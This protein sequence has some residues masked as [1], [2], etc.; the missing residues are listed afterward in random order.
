MTASVKGNLSKLGISDK[1]T[2]APLGELKTPKNTNPDS[3]TPVWYLARLANELMTRQPILIKR[4]RYAEGHHDLPT[5]DKRYMR[6]LLEFR[7]QATTNYYGMIARAPVER[8]SVTGFRFG[9][10]GTADEDAQSIW[11]Y[12]DMD[13]QSMQIH[14][15]AAKYGLAY[16]LVSPPDEES[17]GT[18]A[19]WPTITAEDPRSCIVYRDPV[20]PSRSLAGLRMWVDDVSGY[21]LAM[22]Y[23]S[24]KIYFYQGPEAFDLRG[25]SIESISERLGVMSGQGASGWKLLQSW[26]NEIGE[27]PLVEYI[28]RP[29]S[30]KVPEPEAGDDIRK[31]QDRINQT[32][33]SRIA[34]SHYQAYKQ[35]WVAGADIPKGKK[36]KREAPFDPGFDMLWVTGNKDT[37]FG[38]FSSADISSILEGVRDDVSDIAALSSTPAHY[39]MG[40]V[41]NVSGETLTQ[42]ESAFVSKIQ[43]RQNSMGWSHEKVM[44]LCFA[45]L[46]QKDKATDVTA[47]TLWADPQKQILAE[48]ALAGQQWS[49]IGIP[50]ELIMKRQDWLPDDIEYAVEQKKIADQQALEQ[51]QAQMDMQHSQAMEMATVAG[52]V[53]PGAA[54]KPAPGKPAPGKPVPGKKAA[55]GAAPKPGAKPPVVPKGSPKGKAPGGKK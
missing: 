24:D 7:E 17:D 19:E 36:A 38:E 20:R 47:E 55:P 27:V 46:K 16:A 22:L 50:L 31:V 11:A 35:R 51:Q 30:G 2:L 1:N 13:L 9:P 28:W 4:G 8:M 6:A 25:L 40:K 29:E 53:P 33:F 26:D 14:Y 23:M 15:R 54:G 34:I 5:G 52:K 45:Y 49:A 43:Q 10:V 42:V 32:I 44:K 18:R 39:L 12:N 37:K 41:Q 48:L 3:G 21:I